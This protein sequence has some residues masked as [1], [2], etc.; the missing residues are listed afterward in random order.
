MDIMNEKNYKF[1][2]KN[3]SV[4]NILIYLV[5]FLIKVYFYAKINERLIKKFTLKEFAH[6]NIIS[7]ISIIS[8]V[9]IILI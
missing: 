6:K 2:V 1:L 3:E 5:I 9:I 7:I 4:Y 8:I